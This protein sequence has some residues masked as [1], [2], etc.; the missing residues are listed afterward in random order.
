MSGM[1]DLCTRKGTEGAGSG[2]PE[3]V[4]DFKV[5]YDFIHEPER[6]VWMTHSLTPAGE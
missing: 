6:V 3:N 2:L 1:S 4:L 5:H